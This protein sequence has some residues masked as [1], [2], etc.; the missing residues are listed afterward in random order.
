M[1]SVKLEW[2]SAKVEDATLT[3]ALD[4]EILKVWK[5]SFETTARLLGAGEW[6]EVKLTEDTVQVSDVTA[7]SEDK[8]RHH[9]EGI[10]A[11]ANASQEATEREEE[12]EAHQERG[13]EATGPDAEMTERFRAFA[14]D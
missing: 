14:E 2:A 9:L 8:L 13:G 10:V 7:G 5:Q 12:E 1:S 6:G 4:G 3:V 11:Q